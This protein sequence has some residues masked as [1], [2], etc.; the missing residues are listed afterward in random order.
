[1]ISIVI[2]GG[3][4]D[5]AKKKLFKSLYNL[6]SK[7]LLPKNTKIIGFARR[8]FNSVSYREFVS[9]NLEQDISL[10]EEFL[11]CFYYFQGDLYAK[12]SYQDLKKFLIELDAQYKICASKLFYL[13]VRPELYQNVFTFLKE[14][15]IL[16]TCTQASDLAWS[17]LLIEKPFGTNFEHAKQ[18]DLQLAT[19]TSENNIFRIDHYLA[20]EALENILIFRFKN[21]IFNAIWN[22]DFISQIKITLFEKRDIKGREE[23]YDQVGA[24]KDVGQNH[25]LQMLAMVL[26]DEPKDF[27]GVSIRAEREK[28]LQTITS[29]PI[30][31]EYFQRG[32]Y[33]D[34]VLSVPNPQSQTET[35]FKITLKSS[36]PQWEHVPC[37]IESG[38]AMYK[39]ETSIQIDFTDGNTIFF[40]LQPEPR[41][42][43][44]F[45]VK[46]SG[47]DF[48]TSIKE[49]QFSDTGKSIFSLDAYEKILYQAII[50]DVTSF[51]STQ[52]VLEQWRIIDMILQK[53]GE[54]PLSTY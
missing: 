11:E 29:Y 42:A 15:D 14:T 40:Q 1:M 30:Q 31:S 39:D 45:H 10:R 27:K 43:I 7:N 37:I 51:V 44:S 23:F 17:R 47:Y 35:Y 50:G 32:Q 20:K 19:I 8:D 22:K 49:F 3:T 24:L 53:W 6:Y 41:I 13:S 2:F 46:D 4:G 52:E 36:L 26:M 16:H 9:E 34:F 54:I 28:V 5:L 38:K 33:K 12:E 18:L 21:K 25:A 48:K